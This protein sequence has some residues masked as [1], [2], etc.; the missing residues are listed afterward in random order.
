MAHHST[1]NAQGAFLERAVEFPGTFARGFGRAVLRGVKMMQYGRMLSVLNASSDRQL[2]AMGITRA[3]IP[4]HAA[5]LIDYE[6][7]GL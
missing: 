6:Y 1:I 2:E 3:D 7:D 4:R 5:H